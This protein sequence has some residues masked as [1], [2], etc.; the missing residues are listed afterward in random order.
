MSKS[1][2][3]VAPPQP[4]FGADEIESRWTGDYYVVNLGPI[5]TR[6][7]LFL[8]PPVARALIDSL[9]ATMVAQGDAV[10]HQAVTTEIAGELES[11][12]RDLRWERSRDDG[13]TRIR[14][15]LRS[16]GLAEATAEPRHELDVAAMQTEIG[17]DA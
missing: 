12:A 15:I 6:T 16:G 17:G 14:A 7:K 8:S 11:L 13:L 9:I 4:T 5:E 1:A 2:A 3:F 10:D